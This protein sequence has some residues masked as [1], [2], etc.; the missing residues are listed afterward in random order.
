[1]YSWKLHKL[2]IFKNWIILATQII[3]YM[4]TT[5]DTALVTPINSYASKA[6]NIT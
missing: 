3:K 6:L 1:M 5:L 2:N 4:V